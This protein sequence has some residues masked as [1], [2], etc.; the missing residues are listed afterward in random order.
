MKS[1]EAQ[2]LIKAIQRLTDEVRVIGFGD[3][4]Q[5]SGAQMGALELLGMKLSERIDELT[6]TQ[7]MARRDWFAAF[8]LNAILS[9]EKNWGDP[10]GEMPDAKYRC[11]CAWAY[12]DRLIKEDP[13]F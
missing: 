13:E 6:D 2:Q 8:A 4:T 5:K 9:D 11:K 12:A 3:A 7:S 1:E 10:S